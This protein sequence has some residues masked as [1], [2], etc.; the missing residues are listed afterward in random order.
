MRIRHDRSLDNLI[1]LLKIKVVVIGE[2]VHR[3]PLSFLE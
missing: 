3:K 1:E 2:G